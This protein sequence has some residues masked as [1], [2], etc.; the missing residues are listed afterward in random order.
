MTRDLLLVP[1]DDRP[2]CRQF[3]ARLAA[4]AGHRLAQPPRESLG[5]YLEPG[6]PDEILSWL[7]GH[8]AAQQA[9]LLSL[10]MLCWGGLV[11]SRRMD[12]P[13]APALQ[14]LERVASLARSLPAYAFSVVM[15]TAPTQTNVAEVERAARVTELSLW[16][17]RAEAGRPG[18]E[19]RVRALRQAIPAEWVDAYLGA[20][21]RNH[22]VNLAAL[23]NAAGGDFRFLLLGVDDSRTEGLNVHESR[24]LEAAAQRLRAPAIVA[25]GT[26][27]TAML[28][29][30][31]AVAPGR[32]LTV[33]WSREADRTRVCRY[34]DRDLEGVVEAQSRA[35]G[36]ELRD[37]EDRQLWV[38]GPHGEQTEASGQGR[39]RRSQRAAQFVDDLRRELDRGARIAVADVARA[40]GADLALARELLASGVVP[41]LAGYAAWNTAGNTTGTAL[42]AAALVPDRPTAATERERLCF[43]V[44]RFADDYLYEAELR[45]EV[46][47]PFGGSFVRLEGERLE[48]A[49]RQVRTRL[50]ERVRRL[51][52]QLF[53]DT[54]IRLSSVSV[55][56]PWPRTFEVEVEVTLRA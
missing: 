45:Q 42:A 44:E 27:E 2:C 23:E 28:M 14:R 26:D 43:L 35:A 50:I 31:R 34:E 18:A 41:R 32:A 55:D 38:Y 24:R 29:L 3:P 25:P 21:Q 46:S 8:L 12:L 33:R 10:D 22:S 4:M 30:V 17:A 9:A 51:S 1:L 54:P 52:R 13:L 16:M 39:P 11:A 7:E 53:A 49:R 15:R 19:D 56:L 47:A 37:G 36:L 5:S 6:H 20:R 48:L 40:N